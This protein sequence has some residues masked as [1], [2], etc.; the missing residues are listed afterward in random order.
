[1]ILFEYDDSFQWPPALDE[2]KVGE[3]L[4][5]CLASYG[6]R[7]G[8]L[9]FNMMAKAPMRDVN[10]QVYGRDYDTDTIT[11]AY[12]SPD[13]EEVSADMYISYEQIK[14]NARRFN[15]PYTEELLRV[16]VHS[17]LHAM[18]FEDETP[19]LKQAMHRREDECLKEILS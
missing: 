2:R 13:A 17:L 6:R 9:V 10:R 15:R 14:E 1:M 5:R 18:G 16:L 7:E 11:L 19:A 12:S 3:W 8:M 4:R